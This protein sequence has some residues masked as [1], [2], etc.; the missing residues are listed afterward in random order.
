MGIRRARAGRLA[1]R[2]GASW[3]PGGEGR[4]S[5][6]RIRARFVSYREA[7]F[8]SNFVGG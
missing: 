8:G 4:V 2:R 3:D 5:S 1:D 7:V 6:D